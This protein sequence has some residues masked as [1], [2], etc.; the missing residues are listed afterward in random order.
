MSGEGRAPKLLGEIIAVSK[1]LAPYMIGAFYALVVGHVVTAWI[2]RL[3][4]GRASVSNRAKHDSTVHPAMVGYL[5]RTVLAV[6][7]FTLRFEIA[8]AW[9]VIKVAARW[10]GWEE[11]RDIYNIFLIGTAVSVMIGAAGGY[12]AWAILHSHP[13]RGLALMG[14]AIAL[15][16]F[17]GFADHLPRLFPSDDDPERQVGSSPRER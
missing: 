16:L 7:A 1:V 6:S 13:I 14:A 9:L 11:D 17:L 4:W 2:V 12:G 10:G 15:A 3:A 8:G 5:E